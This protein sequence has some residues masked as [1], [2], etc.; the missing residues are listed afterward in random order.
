MKN[1]KNTPYGYSF[2][3]FSVLWLM[4]LPLVKLVSHL[5]VAHG[6]EGREYEHESPAQDHDVYEISVILE[7]HDVFFLFFAIKHNNEKKTGSDSEAETI[8]N[9]TL[10]GI[11]SPEPKNRTDTRHRKCNRASSR[12]RDTICVLITSSV[13]A[14]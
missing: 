10:T 5:N 8:L 12:R 14:Q 7:R 13:K 6:L 2:S 4:L 11:R 1:T 3:I 9:T